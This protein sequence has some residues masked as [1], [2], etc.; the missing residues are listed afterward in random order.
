MRLSEPNTHG[1]YFGSVDSLISYFKGASILTSVPQGA[2][3]PSAASQTT[4]EW[5]EALT[6]L[7]STG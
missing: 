5:A 1:H 6:L 7:A 4:E 2:D 3:T